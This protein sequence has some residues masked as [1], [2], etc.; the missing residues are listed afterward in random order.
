MKKTTAPLSFSFVIPVKDEQ[1][2]LPIFYKELLTIISSLKKSYEIIFIDDGSTDDSYQKMLELQRSNSHIKIIRFRGNFGKSAALSAGFS[3]AVGKIVVTLDA[4]LQDDPSEI[5]HMIAKLAEGYDVVCA[6]RKIRKDSLSKKISSYLFN[7][8]TI[9]I[10]GVKLHDFNS[11]LKVYKNEVIKELHLHG[12]LH[13]FIPILA[14]KLKFKVTEIPVNH[15]ERK[16]GKSKFGVER[17][18]KGIVDLITIIFLTDYANKPAHF[19]GKIGL[20]FF[21]AGLLMDGYV[22]YVKITTG[23]T[24]DKIPLL[25]AGILFILLGVQLISTGLIAEMI[26]HFS[27]KKPTYDAT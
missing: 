10:S 14:A 16:F 4:D 24:Q 13:R 15:R 17:S 27:Q 6:W 26:S 5:P 21:I 12:E 18:W 9:F 20:F 1:E 23:S 25:L 8:G 7:K 19:F 2:S 22:T 11:G 3:Q